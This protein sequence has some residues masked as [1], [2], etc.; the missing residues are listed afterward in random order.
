MKNIT[1]IFTV[2]EHVKSFEE[3]IESF[4]TN[5]F[6]PNNI[7][8]LVAIDDDDKPML[9]IVS[10]FETIYEKFSMKFFICQRSEHFTKDYWNMLAKKAQG[11]FILPSACDQKMMTKHWDKKIYDK[12]EDAS[13]KYKD[14]ILHGL[15]KDNIRRNGEDPR[16]PNF[17]CNPVLSKKHVEVLGYF[18]DERYWSWGSDQAVT[19]LYKHLW[20]ITKEWRL[21]SL[22]DVEIFTFNSPHVVPDW[23]TEKDV[24][25]MKANDK[26]FQL[27]N[28]IAQ[29]HPCDLDKV[30]IKDLL[31]DLEA[32]K[33]KRY[34]LNKRTKK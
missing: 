22:V 8:F 12:M 19:N 28:R 10:D 3:T 17:S 4:T 9:D 7:E 13:K 24:A 34:I 1:V 18:F 6:N 15:I 30:E 20:S 21:V 11:R 5:A 23:M 29:E 32:E 26:G 2:R 14:D 25:E 33:L 27:H 16:Y 31:Y